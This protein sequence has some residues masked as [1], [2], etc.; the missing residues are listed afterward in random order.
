MNRAAAASSKFNS[1]RDNPKEPRRLGFCRH[2][3]QDPENR[4]GGGEDQ[5]DA[6]R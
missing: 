4:C 1:R 3:E 2:G 6:K 5:P